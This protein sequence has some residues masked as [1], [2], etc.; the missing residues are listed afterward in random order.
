MKPPK[1]SKSA[2]NLPKSQGGYRF[3]EKLGQGGM[4]EVW[5]AFDER[6]DRHVAVKRI[7]NEPEVKELHKERFLREARAAAKLNHPAIVQVHDIFLDESGYNIVMEYVAG[8][9]IAQHLKRGPIPPAPALK[10]A[11]Q[12]AAGLEE[13][14]NHGIVHR[15]LKA[16]NVVIKTTGQAKILDFGLAKSQLSEQADLTATGQLLGTWRTMSPEQARGDKVDHR[17]DLFSLGVLLYEMLSGISPFRGDNVLQTLHNV[18]YEHPQPLE[19]P[20]EGGEL[21]H[22]VS[23][24]LQKEPDQRPFSARRVRQLLERISNGSSGDSE[25]L[26][27]LSAEEP[28]LPA[29]GGGNGLNS[30]GLNISTPPVPAGGKPRPRTSKTARLSALPAVAL[31]VTAVIVGIYYFRFTTREP[32]RIAVFQP[33]LEGAGPEADLLAA[34][35]FDAMLNSLISLEGIVVLD[36]QRVLDSGET[37]AQAA[38]AVGADEVFTAALVFDPILSRLTLRRVRGTDDALLWTQT[39]ELPGNSREALLAA[40]AVA[41]RV[42]RAYA[43]HRPRAG[44]PRIEVRDEDY[45]AFLRLKRSMELSSATIDSERPRIEAIL[46][47]SPR[48]LA[49]YL[50]AGFHAHTHYRNTSNLDSLRLAVSYRDRAAE[51]APGDPRVLQLHFKIAL[52]QNRFEEAADV[53][54]QL[55]RL[56]PRSAETLVLRSRLLQEKGDLNGAVRLMEAA[57]SQRASWRSLLRLANLELQLGDGDGA[58]LHLERLLSLAP[59]NIWGISS[60]AKAEMIYGDLERAELLFEDAAKLLD[61]KSFLANLGTTRYWMGKYEAAG[62]A[63]SRALIRAPDDPILLL[64]LADCKT[65]LGLDAAGR[66]LYTAALEKLNLKNQR[67]ALTP[68][69]TLIKAQCLTHLDAMEEAVRLTLLTL[70]ANPDHA[71]IAFQAALVY[72]RA[73]EKRSALACVR[74]AIGKGIQLRWFSDPGFDAMRSDPL[75][76]KLLASPKS[77]T[78]SGGSE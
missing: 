38:R 48:F 46:Q 7:R 26:S 25:G 70:Q 28:I 60:L 49:A 71:E 23:W 50:L 1:P 19:S 61:H 41:T 22:L 8:Q 78:Q 14:H 13:A 32:V 57:V 21:F 69:E 45:T 42:R 52:S 27:N 74:T 35:V 18:Q 39:L 65:A 17:T 4:G 62:E 55:D 75:F 11:C 68:M 53:L 20:S 15:D 34:V 51:I 76:L 10:W 77:G 3:V 54:D 9:T 43:G 44:V 12:I 5:L 24:L 30:S 33:R 72:A 16:E 47:R 59:G 56:E 31:A 6:L 2:G 40:E 63:F 58:R 73:G 66:G 29:S 36:P 37:A 64:G 67:A